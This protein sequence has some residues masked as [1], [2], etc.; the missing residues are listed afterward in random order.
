MIPAKLKDFFC[1]RK[2]NAHEKL[3]WFGRH[4]PKFIDWMLECFMFFQAVYC[5]GLLTALVNDCNGDVFAST[6]SPLAWA[7]WLG[8]WIPPI[9]NIN[10]VT[11]VMM[12]RYTMVCSVEHMK[13]LESLHKNISRNKKRS[14]WDAVQLLHLIKTHNRVKDVEGGTITQ[15]E[16]TK[17]LLHHARLSAEKREYVDELFCHFDVKQPFGSV[18]VKEFSEALSLT[19]SKN[20]DMDSIAAGLLNMVDE[21]LGKSS[22][23]MLLDI[24][25]S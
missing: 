20:D 19:G 1:D 6:W 9:V 25:L 4:G 8:C 11:P 3:F 21:K 12:S 16:F 13:D 24:S 17:Y 7:I 5:A 2:G 23:I 14:L 10:Y 15:E 22:K 18:D